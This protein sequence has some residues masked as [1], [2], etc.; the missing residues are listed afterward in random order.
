[1]THS[2]LT[3]T[4]SADARPAITA[5]SSAMRRVVVGGT[6]A[7]GKTTLASRLAGRLGVPHVELDA[8]HWE[9]GWIEAPNELFRARTQEALS[10]NCWVVDG[11]YSVVRDIVWGRADTVIF[12]DYPLIV[13]LGRLLRRTLWR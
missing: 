9:A 4:A 8:L 1:M 3:R 6:S 12:L 11:N 10:G 13:I 5:H 2:A 7:S